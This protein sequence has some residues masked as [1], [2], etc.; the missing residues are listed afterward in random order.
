M[1]TWDHVFQF[2]RAKINYYEIKEMYRVVIKVWQIWN[3]NCSVHTASNFKLWA[4]LE[5]CDMWF[6]FDINICTNVSV[7]HAVIHNFLEVAI[8]CFA[9]FQV[10]SS[11]K[12]CS[13]TSNTGKS[14]KTKIDH[15]KKMINY[16][17]KKGHIWSL[18]SNKNHI[19]QLSNGA[20]SL[21]F[22]AVWTE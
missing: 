18:V 10:W 22:D 6:L 14:K 16:D 9:S 2:M 12:K 19:S 8:F 5:S 15:V 20:H 13:S 3:S 21:K 17:M 4:P 1:R 7:F 11:A